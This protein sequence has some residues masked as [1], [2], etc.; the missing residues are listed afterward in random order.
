MHWHHSPYHNSQSFGDSWL[1][2]G[3]GEGISKGNLYVLIMLPYNT[4]VSITMTGS[5]RSLTSYGGGDGVSNWNWYVAAPFSLSYVSIIRVIHLFHNVWDLANDVRR[6]CKIQG[7]T[8]HVIVAGDASQ[9]KR[10]SD[11]HSNNTQVHFYVPAIFVRSAI[12]PLFLWAVWFLRLF[13]EF[14]HL[15]FLTPPPFF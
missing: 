1:P 10:A 8:E 2:Y 4:Y 5:G 6:W 13:A 3:N 11:N 12:L 14:P 7:G 9:G 15:P